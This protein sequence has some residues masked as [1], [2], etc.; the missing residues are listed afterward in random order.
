MREME[1][2]AVVRAV[3]LVLFSKAAELLEPTPPR[4]SIHQDNRTRRP[5]YTALEDFCQPD[6]VGKKLSFLHTVLDHR[7]TNAD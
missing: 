4:P 7:L 5:G 6:L 2:H 1:A 3:L